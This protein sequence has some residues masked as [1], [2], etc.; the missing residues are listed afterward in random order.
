VT[1]ECYHKSGLPETANRIRKF[2]VNKI[3]L[4]EKIFENQ[5]YFNNSFGN[6][7]AGGD[8][9]GVAPLVAENEKTNIF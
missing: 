6:H 9:G 5:N 1:G 4:E 3:Q 2:K 8:G 7:R